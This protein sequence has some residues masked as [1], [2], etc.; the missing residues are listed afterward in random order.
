M[1][2]AYDVYELMPKK[3]K[4]KERFDKVLKEIENTIIEAAKRDENKVEVWVLAEDRYYI[5]DVLKEH[6]YDHS[7]LRNYRDP[8]TNEN[9]YL[10]G[11]WWDY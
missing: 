5:G 11:I 4:Q 8:D 2:D 9:K 1:I 3:K 10:V 6:H 7:W